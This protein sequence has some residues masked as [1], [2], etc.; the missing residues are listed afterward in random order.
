MPAGSIGKSF[1]AAV[2]LDFV[3]DGK[4]QLDGKV[5]DWFRQDDWYSGSDRPIADQLTLSHCP[6]IIELIYR[7]GQVEGHHPD[8]CSWMQSVHSLVLQFQD[9]VLGAETGGGRTGNPFNHRQA[10][11]RPG[12]LMA[13]IDYGPTLYGVADYL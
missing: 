5:E 13:R 4:L 7:K 1:V 8:L 6:E 10:F 9:A 3:R 11:V 2:V 12:G